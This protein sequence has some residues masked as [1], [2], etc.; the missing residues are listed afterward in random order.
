MSPVPVTSAQEALVDLLTKLMVHSLI[1]RLIPRYYARINSCLKMFYSSRQ[2]DIFTSASLESIGGK[3]STE[4][5]GSATISFS[6][7]SLSIRF[8]I[9]FK[10]GYLSFAH[11]CPCLEPESNCDRKKRWRMHFQDLAYPRSLGV[12]LCMTSEANDTNSV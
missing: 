8:N 11:C 10:A 3:Y 7:F 2:S 1:L 9:C 5:A 6:L 12:L 4:R